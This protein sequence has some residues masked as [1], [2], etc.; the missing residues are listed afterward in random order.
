MDENKI[1]EVKRNILAANDQAADVFRAKRKEEG[2]F[3]VDIMASPGAGK[4]TLLIAL[5][6]RLRERGTAGVIEADLESD[7]DALKMKEAGVTSVELN[8]LG[9]C[10]VEM[11]MMQKAFDAF[12]EMRFDYLFL[13]NIGNL[14]CPAD[15]DTGA[16]LRVMLLSVPEG[17]DKVYKYPPM[18]AVC[19]ALVVTKSDY[20]PMNPDFDMEALK[21]QAR[22]LNP[23]LEILV[24]SARTG[25]GMDELAGWIE[26][27]RAAEIG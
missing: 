14:V 9:V 12:G 16:H 1:I 11:N 21:K 19:D 2:T 5:I 8:T 3:V 22:V 18:F 13:E 4:T 25:E 20:L 24:T 7:V 26:R 10:H 23:N 17:Y 6:E 27:R 15:F